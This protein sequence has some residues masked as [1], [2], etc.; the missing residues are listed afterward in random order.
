LVECQLPKLDVA[1]SNPVLRSIF[2]QSPSRSVCVPSCGRRG[3]YP[4]GRIQSEQGG[5]I[6]SHAQVRHVWDVAK[7]LAVVEAVA[8]EEVVGDF[9]A[10]V[11][12]LHV[13]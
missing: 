7:R 8:D 4:A 3:G 13:Y 9:E 11:P 6:G 2:P 5:L 12:H 1:G 10:R